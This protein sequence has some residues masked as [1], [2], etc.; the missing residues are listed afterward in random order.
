MLVC[1]SLS[2]IPFTLGYLLS[3]V[4][5]VFVAVSLV[6]RWLSGSHGVLLLNPRYFGAQ[7][8][9]FSPTRASYMTVMSV[10]FGNWLTYPDIVSAPP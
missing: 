5:P 1:V 10:L 4:E 3:H 2:V 7:E 6:S 9:S 8:P